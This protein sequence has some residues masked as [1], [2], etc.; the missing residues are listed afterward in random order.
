M[1]HD[2]TAD[3][4]AAL[5][6]AVQQQ[7]DRHDSATPSATTPAGTT[8]QNRATLSDRH[9]VLSGRCGTP[10]TS[11]RW[12]QTGRNF[13]ADRS[14]RR[15]HKYPRRWRRADLGV[16]II[17]RQVVQIAECSRPVVGLIYMKYQF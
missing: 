10:E 4:T 3:A 9:G 14:G 2:K 13:R 11:R 1:I 6:R 16:R 12:R 5:H 15:R 8:W 17:A 7:Q